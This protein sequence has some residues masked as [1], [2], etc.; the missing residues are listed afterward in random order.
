MVKWS[1]LNWGIQVCMSPD[2]EADKNLGKIRLSGFSPLPQDPS[3]PEI[4]TRSEYP[5]AHA[6]AELVDNSIIS[7]FP[8][9]SSLLYRVSNASYIS[10]RTVSTKSLIPTKAL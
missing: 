3:L 9:S 5:L 8:L 6:V 4:L 2:T 7:V 1:G 10:G